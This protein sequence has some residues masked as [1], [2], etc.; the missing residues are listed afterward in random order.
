MNSF[1]QSNEQ[2]YF[3]FKKSADLKRMLIRTKF[4]QGRK[5]EREKRQEELIEN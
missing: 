4:K 5:P 1:L 2:A 3:E